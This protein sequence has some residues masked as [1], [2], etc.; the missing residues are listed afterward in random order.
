MKRAEWLSLLDKIVSP[1]L[2][3]LGNEKLHESLPFSFHPDRQP[4]GMLEAFG[5]TL[6][7][8]GPWIELESIVNPEEKA[9]QVHYHQLIIKA[10]NNATNLK[11]KDYMNFSDAG[12]PLVDAAFLSHFILRAPQFSKKNLTGELRE[13]IIAALVATRKIVPPNTNWNLFSAM[14][15]GALAVLEC[16]YDILRVVY[17]VR[18]L[19]DWYVGDGVYGDGPKFQWDYYNSFVIQPMMID[20]LDLFSD[21]CEELAKYRVEMLPR[22]T[23]YAGIQERLIAPDGSYPIIGRS[24][25]YRFGAFQALAQA[26]LQ[27]RLPKEVSASQVRCALSAVISKTSQSTDMFDKNGWLQPGVYGYQPELAESYIG[28]GSLY[29]ATAIFLPLGLPEQHPF[30]S[31]KAKEWTAKKVWS[32]KTSMIDQSIH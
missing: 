24:I 32:G 14:V 21:E 3:N 12:Q 4:Y 18:L 31:G 19:D 29:L 1:V 17:A 8:M 2:S 11:S 6:V 22:F 9:L 13:Q 20:L 16:D 25:I 10:F 23:R 30:W 7:G 26:A 28:V 27:E 15:E 5:R